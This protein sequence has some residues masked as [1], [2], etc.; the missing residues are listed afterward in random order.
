M[1]PLFSIIIPTSNSGELINKSLCSIVQQTFTDYEI[2]IQDGLSIDNTISIIEEIKRRYSS[3]SIKVFQEQDRGVYDAMNKALKKANGE[4][5]Y[6]LGSDDALYDKEVLGKVNAHITTS[7]QKPD[8]VYGNV[9]LKSTGQPYAGEVDLKRLLTRENICHQSIFYRKDT[10]ER[11][12]TYNLR[13][14][15]WADWDLNI[16]CFQHPEVYIIYI[17]E[18]IAFYNDELGTS[19]QQ[20]DE[21][22]YPLL[23]VFYI[24][25]SDTEKQQIKA[26][27]QSVS[28]CIGNK[29][30]HLVNKLGIVPLIKKFS[31]ESKPK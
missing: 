26:I 18:V 30:Y 15:I 24:H 14:K 13:Y 8:V 19:S 25:Q 1:I 4:W 22:L 17:D 23:P 3:I 28:Y 27:T 31:R 16:R 11:V 7:G 10:F 6:F 5:I 21:E 12:G 2:I 29:V 9:L 20:L